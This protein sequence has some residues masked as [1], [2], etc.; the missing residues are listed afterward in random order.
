M[1]ATASLFSRSPR[2]GIHALTGA[3][4]QIGTETAVAT[5]SPH[6]LVALLFQGLFDA[7]QKARGAIRS[8]D[9]VGKGAALGQASRIVEE[10]LKASLNLK[11]GGELA[12]NL[13]GLY[14]Y[15]VAR[16]MYANLRS[17]ETALDECQ[18]LLAP[19]RDAW[20]GIAHLTKN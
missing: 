14:T 7:M 13:H 11:D 8:G 6:K 10:G 5:A 16:L 9:V 4:Q 12:S 18:A 1:Y 2:L 15:V 19:V 20:A 3:Y 17:D